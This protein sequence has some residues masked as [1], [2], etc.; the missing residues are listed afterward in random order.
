RLLARERYQQ[1]T[2]Q[3]LG[4]PML[5]RRRIGRAMSSFILSSIV[6]TDEKIRA[7]LEGYLLRD[8]G[9]GDPRL[10]S[11]RPN[12]EAVDPAARQRVVAWLSR[13]DLL[14]FYNFVIERD[15][16]G[17]KPFWLRYIDQVQDSNVVLCDDDERRLNANT[18]V[19][20]RMRYSRV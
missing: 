6:E 4:W 3:L 12:W 16:H 20:E 15:P 9:F 11:K 19:K 17:R 1:L 8:P 5:D 18:R 7:D 14:F 2:A 13:Q 10:P